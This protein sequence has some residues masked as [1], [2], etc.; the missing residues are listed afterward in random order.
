MMRYRA[1]V[2]GLGPHGHRMVD[3]LASVDNVDLAAVLDRRDEALSGN[4]LPQSAARCRD[5]TELWRVQKLDL[6]CIATNGPSHAQIALEAMERGIQRLVIAKPMACSLAECDQILNL[7]E[8]TKSRVAVDHIRRHAS[9]FVW[10]RRQISLGTWGEVR[11]V[12][13]QRPG[14]GLGCLA[15]HSFDAVRFLTGF[16]VRQVTGWVDQPLGKNPRGADFVDPGGLVVMELDRNARAIISQIEDGAGPASIEI[17]LTAGRIRLDEKSGEIEVIERDLAV[18]AGPGRPPVYRRA[19]LPV[20]LTAKVDMHQ[21]LVALL[22]DLLSDGPIECSGEQGRA[23]IEVLAAAHLSH[24]RGNVPV[25][26]RNSDQE[27]SQL[28]LPVT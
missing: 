23:S 7:A 22:R 8:R 16:D 4:N 2:I 18:K 20:G 24:R 9:A 1:A 12:W 11:C 15:T 21:G 14:M 25:P 28:W 5:L 26:L 17:D 27:L 6:V 3:A 10:I 13:M 19:E